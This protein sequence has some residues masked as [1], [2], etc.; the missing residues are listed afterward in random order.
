[1]RCTLIPLLALFTTACPSTDAAVDPDDGLPT[2]PAAN[3]RDLSNKVEVGASDGL[4]RITVPSG[5]AFLQ[6]VVRNERAL[7]LAVRLGQAPTVSD[8]LCRENQAVTNDQVCYIHNPA[9]GDYYISLNGAITGNVRIQAH[10]EPNVPGI[11]ITPLTSGV[12][13]SQQ[14]QFT[15]VKSYYSIFVP[16][17]VS[18]TQRLDVRTTG[19]NGNA[20]LYVGRGVS[21]VH[22]SFEILCSST[23]PNTSNETCGFT[24]QVVNETY[25]IA[26]NNTLGY[27]GL[28]ITATVGSTS[29]P[30]TTPTPPSGG[31]GQ[32]DK[33]GLTLITVGSDKICLSRLVPGYTVTGT[34]ATEGGGTTYR[35]QLNADGTGSTDNS[36]MWNAAS[37]RTPAQEP[38][39]QFTWGVRVQMN[40]DPMKVQSTSVGEMHHIYYKPADRDWSVTSLAIVYADKRMIIANDRIKR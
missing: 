14:A 31:N 18:G 7:I 10:F 8:Y 1:M 11:V 30:P 12:A 13:L 27:V 36:D 38:R 32:C 3:V 33:P 5:Q 40:G 9:P 25:Y 4:Y 39:T 2:A 37:P 19:G 16:R 23:A 20:D 26:V 35:T 6:V 15:G 34:Y 17:A 22:S 28:S 21:P 24:P 29:A